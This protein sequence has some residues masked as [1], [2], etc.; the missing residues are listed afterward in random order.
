M[1]NIKSTEAVV[2]QTPVEVMLIC[3]YCEHKNECSYDGACFEDMS[4]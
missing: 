1:E 4:D 3:P 2:Y